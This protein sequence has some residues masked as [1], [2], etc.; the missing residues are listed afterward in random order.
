MLVVYET[1]KKKVVEKR[2]SKCA[3]DNW[4]AEIDMGKDGY[5]QVREKE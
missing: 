4:H 2:C 3:S 5:K 1:E